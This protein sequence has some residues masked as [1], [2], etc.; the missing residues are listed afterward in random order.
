MWDLASIEDKFKLAQDN[1]QTISSGYTWDHKTISFSFP[2]SAFPGTGAF[3]PEGE[4]LKYTAFTTSEIDLTIKFLDA[5][6]RAVDIDFVYDAT[7]NGE[8]K[9]GKQNMDEWTGGY[10]TFP[11]PESTHAVVL[12]NVW[13]PENKSGAIGLLI[14]EFGH[15]LGLEHPHA[16]TTPLDATLDVTSAT[17][18][19]YNDF[20][21]I[22]GK[23]DY[24][25]ITSYSL[26]DILALQSMYGV[27]RKVSDDIYQAD[28]T[29]SVVADYG[30]TDAIDISTQRYDKADINI[31][32][33][34]RGFVY[35][36][37]KGGN[38]SSSIMDPDNGWTEIIDRTSD[39]GFY[40]MIITPGTVIEKVVG[41]AVSD[42]ITGASGEETLKGLGGNDRIKGGEGADGITGGKGYDILEGGPGDDTFGFASAVEAGKGKTCDV[43]TDF[44]S[45][46][47]V[48]DLSGIFVKGDFSF[49]G[50]V[51]FHQQAGELRA[52]T[53][54]N[55]GNA[56]DATYIE[57]DLN[58]NGVADFQIKLTGLHVLQD[59][60]FIL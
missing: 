29:V 9:F 38:W 6:E 1:F 56:K 51:G 49:I 28:G 52:F 60:D 55:L 23:P 33:L 50:K 43:I 32:D 20:A 17:M 16:P 41:S 11:A 7:G 30:G 36:D 54:D 19:S 22:Q 39:N 26:M 47:D 13:A 45:G 31:V 48:I 27:S 46:E 2:V 15:S 37:R 18:L 34:S 57:G 21:L 12:S 24:F 14:H 40:N 4:G 59:A 10:A 42:R 8:I 44:V 25:R 58:G 53:K 35:Y 5:I 3:L